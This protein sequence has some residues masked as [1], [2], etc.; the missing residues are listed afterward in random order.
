M[1][2]M[3]I[4]WFPGHM[5]A[6]LRMMEKEIKL[7][8][9]VIYML[10]ARAPISCLNPK[11][12]EVIGNKPIIYVLNKADLAPK[13]TNFPHTAIAVNSTNTGAGKIIMQKAYEVLKPK[14]D[15]AKAK[16]INK[17]LRLMVLGVPNCGKSTFI[18]NLC[19]KYKA[20]TG[21]KPGVTRGK[22]WVKVNDYF[23]LLDTPGTL[24][25]AF[26]NPQVARNLAY[27]GSIKD[28]VLNLEELANSLIEDVT[29]LNKT[30]VQVRFG[31]TELKGICIKRGCVLKGGVPDIERGAKAILDDFRSGKLGQFN[32]DELL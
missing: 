19:G 3:N 15:A 26:T 4:Q 21:N 27:I 23:E 28:E 17:V 24:W 25:P 32:L 8:D 7:A 12:A 9:G 5:T 22:Q 1:S 14:I 16:G 10:D 2:N 20:I 6:A 29:K 31:A 18:N 11:F 13:K 30:A